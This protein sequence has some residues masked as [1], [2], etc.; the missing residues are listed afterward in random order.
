MRQKELAR[1]QRED[2]V[3]TEIRPAQRAQNCCS[4]FLQLVSPLIMSLVIRF[5]D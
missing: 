4:L 1:Q 5:L 2:S 3:S